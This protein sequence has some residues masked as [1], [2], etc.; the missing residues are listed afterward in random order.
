MFVATVRRSLYFGDGP[1]K[2]GLIVRTAVGFAGHKF[3]I[4]QKYMS[5]K[6][7]SWTRLVVTTPTG[8]LVCDLRE[9]MSCVGRSAPDAQ[10]DAYARL[11]TRANQ[12]HAN[13]IF[14]AVNIWTD[15]TQVKAF[16]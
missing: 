1:K 6:N 11:L 2:K 3:V 16:T 5:R 10:E 13:L 8:G 9:I 14:N 7:A 4:E 12:I 15:I